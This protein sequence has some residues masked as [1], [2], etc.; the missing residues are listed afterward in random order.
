M[1]QPRSMRRV[2][3]SLLFITLLSSS[4][5]V[6]NNCCY[7]F[8]TG[9]NFVQLSI[10]TFDAFHRN[11]NRFRWPPL[12]FLFIDFFFRN[13][14]AI[15]IYRHAAAAVVALF[16]FFAMKF[17]FDFHAWTKHMLGIES[18]IGNDGCLSVSSSFVLSSKA[19][20]LRLSLFTVGVI[21]NADDK[22]CGGHSNCYFPILCAV[23]G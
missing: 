10:P 14:A 13:V 16:L 18:S 21:I 20:A 6:V 11:R 4:S 3:V 23:C 19:I 9:I 1:L 2:Y 22:V 12:C 8:C 5:V 17:C 7:C 15:P